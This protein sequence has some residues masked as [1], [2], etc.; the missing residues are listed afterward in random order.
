MD[1][2]V[3]GGIA[4]GVI[5]FLAA[6]GVMSLA[7]RRRN[8]HVAG[9][10]NKPTEGTSVEL[11]VQLT[12]SV[13][14]FVG[15][16]TNPLSTFTARFDARGLSFLT[17]GKSAHILGNLPWPEVGDIQLASQGLDHFMTV[18]LGPTRSNLDLVVLD[19]S[20]P[21][22]LADPERLSLW[23]TEIEKVR[24]DAVAT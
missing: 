23:L 10:L 18:N 13:A 17:G 14:R 4:V 16:R 6:L 2:A 7:A 21:G 24:G 19:P 1:P 8:Q 5:I 22:R 15:R 11:A 12:E 20:Q 9:R 3:L